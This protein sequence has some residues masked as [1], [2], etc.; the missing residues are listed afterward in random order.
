MCFIFGGDDIVLH[1]AVFVFEVNKYSE[2]YQLGDL[3]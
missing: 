3:S 1:G 2:C